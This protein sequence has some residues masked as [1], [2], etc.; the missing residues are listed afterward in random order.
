MKKFAAALIAGATLAAAGSALADNACTRPQA[1]APLDGKTAT[2]DQV[3]AKKNDVTAFMTASDTYQSCL[4]DALAAQ[5]AAAKAN[6]TEVPASAVKDANAQL[7]A[8]QTDKVKVGQ[9]FNDAVH[10]FRASHPAPA[11]H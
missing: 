8:N 9:A 4:I 2:L 10:V 7:D 6:K 3:L 1:P 11:A 5:R